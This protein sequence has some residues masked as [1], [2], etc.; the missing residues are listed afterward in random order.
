MNVGPVGAEVREDFRA[1][2]PGERSVAMIK[3]VYSIDY[4]RGRKREYVDWVRSIADT[5]QKPDELQRLA[6]YDNVFSA[7]PQRIV[8][9]S[10]E[11]LVDAATYF[12]RP[13]MIRIFGGELSQHGANVGITVLRRLT[14]YTKDTGGTV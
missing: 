14:D 10:F 4:P 13:E 1:R 2:C 7:S 9:F 5:L 11:S 3:Y 8:E 6:S 12:E